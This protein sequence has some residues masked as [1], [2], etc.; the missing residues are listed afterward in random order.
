MAVSRNSNLLLFLG[1]IRRAAVKSL[2][3]SNFLALTFSVE[4]FAQTNCQ[5]LTH[6]V[7]AVKRESFDELPQRRISNVKLP[8]APVIL[9]TNFHL[10]WKCRKCN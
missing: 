5:L 1:N 4:S 10:N 8:V 2:K 7:N 3:T 6:I 9:D